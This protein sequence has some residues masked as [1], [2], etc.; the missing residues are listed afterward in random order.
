MA[1][2]GWKLVDGSYYP[3]EIVDDAREFYNALAPNR[4]GRT[5]LLA[6]KAKA[7]AG[8]PRAIAA[9]AAAAQVP[10]TPQADVNQLVSPWQ[11][12]HAMQMYPMAIHQGYAPQ[13]MPKAQAAKRQPRAANSIAGLGYSVAAAVLLSCGC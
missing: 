13:A 6:A 7:K 2:H 8:L 11:H 1:P 10:W 9:P 12:Q 4:A 3:P 5:A